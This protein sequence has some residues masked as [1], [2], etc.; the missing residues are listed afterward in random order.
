MKHLLIDAWNVIHACRELR[1]A[2]RRSGEAAVAGLVAKVRGLGDEHGWRV[3]IVCDSRAGTLLASVA[4]D[5]AVTCVQAP[6]NKT[7][8]SVIEALVMA[9]PAGSCVVVTGDLA[10]AS[11]VQAAGAEVM[12]PADLDDWLVRI[13]ERAS[14]RLG[15]ANAGAGKLATLGDLLEG[16]SARN[17]G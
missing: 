13:S 9:A 6:A 11:L 14:R 7:A 17:R 1:A 12:S 10:E 3:T 16:G 8:D 2:A 4:S 15:R 5:S